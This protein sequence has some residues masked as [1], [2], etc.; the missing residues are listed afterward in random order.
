[1]K[2]IQEIQLH[3]EEKS[4]TE[5]SARNTT[6]AM[7]A[8]VI[9]ILL[10][11]CTRVVFT[12][13]L[14]EAYVG[15]NGLFTDILNVLAL[16]ELGIST[17]ITYALYK[18]IAEKDIEKQKSLM[19]LYKR[20]YRFVALIVLVAGLCV[21]PFMDVLI[22]NE[23]QVENLIFLYLMYLANSVISYLLV[24][25]RTLIEA[26]QL[27]Y[28]GV[29]YQ[30]VFLIIQNVVQM[31]VLLT[32]KNFTLFLSVL[33]LCTLLNNLCISK[34][35]DRMYPFLKEKQVKPLAD[36]EKQG[37]YQN[38]RAMLMHKVGNV[39]VNNTDNLLLSSM[40]GIVSVGMYSNYYLVIGSVRQVLNQAFQ[41]ITA[42]VGNLGVEESKERVHRI[43]EAAFFIGQWMFGFATIC[44]FELLTPFVELSFGSNYVFSTTITFILCLNFYFTGMRQATLVFRD[45]LGLFW[46]DRYKS[47]AEA[48]I[49][50]VVSIILGLQFGVA[51]IF[52]G[53]LCSTLLTSFWVEPYML[54]KHRL[55]K[56][57]CT[58]FVK[59]GVYLAVMAAAWGLTHQLCS[60]V[61]GST[62][63]QCVVRLS[64][65]LIIPNVLFLVVYCRC[66]EFSFVLA[67]AKKMFVKWLG[68]E[69]K[70][71][72]NSAEFSAEEEALFRLL[73]QCLLP[74]SEKRE[75]VLSEAEWGRLADIAQK[76]GVLSLL[77]EELCERQTLPEHLKKL[78]DSTASQIVLQQYR[79]LFTSKF[80]ADLFREKKIPVVLLKGVTVGNLY[81]VPELRKSGDVDILLLHPDDLER[82]TLILEEAGCTVQEKQLALHHVCFTTPEGIELELHTMLVEPF[83]SEKT[84][85]KLK[86]IL[87]EAGECQRTESVMGIGL[88]VLS[89]AYYPFELL[90]HMLQHFLRSGFGLKLL[91]DWVCYWQTERPKEEKEAYISLVNRVGIKGF[92]DVVTL[93]CVRFLGLNEA[94]ISWMDCD[95]SRPVEEFMR[96]IL[97]A[98][99]FG[100]SVAERMVVMRG[101][102]LKDYI[103]EFHHQMRLNFPKAGRCIFLWPALWI[104]TL[105]R[106]AINNRK[107]RKT[108]TKRILSEAARRSRMMQNLRLFR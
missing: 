33:I 81:P 4:R 40:V 38:I 99:E 100:K 12:H 21:L 18:P 106:F 57:V 14:S 95:S 24:Y 65:C 48:V 72:H 54:Y 80:V 47:L 45:S 59:Y 93:T 30:T 85:L 9:A 16:S 42:S 27:S 20:F 39:V 75:V 55:Q 7:C 22:K 86:K 92:S 97:D 5:Y 73:Q 69:D 56:P 35:A 91:A 13:T 101:T 10:G 51:G 11:F 102:G 1:M 52:I 84:N 78:V 98:E 28:I 23:E 105:T 2:G 58:Y 19:Q 46:Y 25:K 44:L 108:S 89:G 43:F 88:P 36:A 32:T 74:E 61:I 50:L 64:I 107:L 62:F 76:H 29:L 26:H 53:T 63:T 37:I 15:I 94:L 79:L 66:K 70:K 17:A 6:V 3:R 60:R 82:A 83:D 90:L 67:K 77:Y 87:I 49:N 104:A 34:K 68:K 31:V 96:E 71:E 41:G 103:R 8:R